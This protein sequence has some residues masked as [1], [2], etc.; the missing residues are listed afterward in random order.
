MCAEIDELP[1]SQEE[2]SKGGGNLLPLLLALILAT[3]FPLL[4]LLL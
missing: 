3:I 2:K 1:D 4:I